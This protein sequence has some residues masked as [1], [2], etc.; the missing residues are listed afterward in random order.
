[1][2]S[3]RGAIDA[4]RCRVRSDRAFAKK[5]QVDERF[6]QISELL[7]EEITRSSTLHGFATHDTVLI[8]R[9]QGAAADKDI[10]KSD[11]EFQMLYGI[12]NKLQQ[13]LAAAGYGVRALISYGDAWYPW[14]MRRLAER[15]ANVWF[16]LKNV[17]KR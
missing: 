15:P 10:P 8:E 1:M 11:L 3:C 2:V 9:I 17:F 6:L 16:A 13:Q 5:T 7:L 14:Y 4:V 12:Q